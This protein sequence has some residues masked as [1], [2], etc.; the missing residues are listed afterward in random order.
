MS[1]HFADQRGYV[2][3]A[4]NDEDTT[5]YQSNGR[6]LGIVVVILSLTICTCVAITSQ[7][8]SV[9]R[10]ASIGGG[11]ALYIG[12]YWL[13]YIKFIGIRTQWQSRSMPR[14]IVYWCGLLLCTLL[15]YA[16]DPAYVYMLWTLVGLSVGILSM[17]WTAIL[18]AIPSL[19]LLLSWGIWPSD[20]SPRAWL[21][22]AGALLSFIIYGAVIYLPSVLIHQRYVQA[23]LYRDLEATHHDL[24]KAH[25]QLTQSAE[26]E[27]EIA[28]LRE[29]ERLAREMHDTLGHALVLTS[30][31]LE[32]VRRLAT[33]D[34]ERADAQVVSTQSVVRGVMQELRATLVALRSPALQHTAVAVALSRYAHEAGERTGWQVVY[35]ICET[36]AGWPDA[37]QE[38][39]L[40]IGTEAINN[41]EQHAH[42]H[43]L[44]LTVMSEQTMACL[45]IADDGVGLPDLPRTQAGSATSSVGHFGLAGIHERIAEL[46]GTVCI[47]SEANAGT[48]LTVRVPLPAPILENV[49]EA[50]PV[51]ITP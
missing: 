51:R 24:A 35:H 47:I 15:L 4:R 7:P 33:I 39:L 12:W 34:P 50:L 30:V 25:A 1:L 38:A 43:Q 44:S 41:A 5:V 42:A 6:F 26:Q 21:G 28:V 8:I 36:S 18:G 11:V 10:V 14:T 23:Q 48:H 40:R 45:E 13:G 16:L 20:N 17:P 9:R 46:G 49:A 19:L 37:V 29:R 31:K 2:F 32:A 3:Y 27:R 22:F